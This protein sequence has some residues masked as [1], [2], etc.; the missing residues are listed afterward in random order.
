M[1][2]LPQ[3]I[4]VS[5]VRAGPVEHVRRR[6]V[7]AT[8]DYRVETSSDGVHFATRQG[9]AAFTPDDLHAQHRHA[10]RRTRPASRYVRLTLLSP[11]SAEPG[12]SGVDFIDF[13]E[14]E[15]FGGP[16]NALPTGAL[17]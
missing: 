2:E 3:A 4:D 14:L 1:I 8:K 7:V 5:G 6:P 9:R 16:P 15:V 12:D 17:P 13:S 10:D 11:Q